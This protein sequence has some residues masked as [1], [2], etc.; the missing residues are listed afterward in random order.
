[1]F[2]ELKASATGIRISETVRADWADVQA[3]ANHVQVHF[4]DVGHGDAIL[5]RIPAQPDGSPE[6][7]VIVD[8]GPDLQGGRPG[9]YGDRLIEY[10][11]HYG[12]ARN[13]RIDYAI[14]THPLTDVVSGLEDVLAEYQVA[15][16][17][18]PALNNPLNRSY[19]RFL[20]AARQETAGGQKAAVVE[21]DRPGAE[22]KLS[23]DVR[24]NVL[25]A[26]GDG[27]KDLGKG[28][29]RRR[30]GSLVLRLTAGQHS[31]LLMGGARAA[32]ESRLLQAGAP[33]GATVLRAGDHASSDTGT[34]PFI[35]AVN[36]KAIVVSAGIPFG[37]KDAGPA[38]ET[39][40]RFAQFAPSAIVARTDANDRQEGHDE[41]TD[42]DG[43][44]VLA[45]TDGRELVLLQAELDAGVRRWRVLMNIPPAVAS[46]TDSQ[47][48]AV[49]SPSTRK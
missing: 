38:A 36:P 43:D 16:V 12:L 22:V 14:L 10:L 45:V 37:Q 20:A 18:Y 19:R 13:S 44:D 35:T 2:R 4:I 26:V 47:G 6:Q 21:I 27:G 41:L 15:N 28:D 11:R 49:V 32:V 7:N 9:A 48:T 42:S 8:G 23:R 30:N 1:M 24:L 17:W 39:L 40:R 29:V 34:G 25:F 46:V 33:L 3:F 5:I 31:F